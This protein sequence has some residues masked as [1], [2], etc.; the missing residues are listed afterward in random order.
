MWDGLDS[1][2]GVSVKPAARA[3]AP[4]QSNQDTA[5][6]APPRKREPFNLFGGVSFFGG[7]DGALGVSAA[8]PQ[9][10]GAA[11]RPRPTPTPL[12][13]TF[14]PGRVVRDAKDGATRS[15]DANADDDAP[16]LVV[17]V[18][19][20]ESHGGTWDDLVARFVA[21]E[22]SS[23]SFLAVDLRGHGRTPVGNEA[24]FTPAALAADVAACVEAHAGPTRAAGRNV[25][26]VGHSMGA[27]VA[28]RVC[29]DFPGLGARH[30]VAEDM[31][32]RVFEGS[33]HFGEAFGE[34]GF[35]YDRAR[36]FEPNAASVEAMKASLL[37]A[38]GAFTFSK[39]SV[40][41]YVARG[42]LFA[43]SA[44]R[45]VSLVHP[46]GFC[47]AFD[48]ILASG[49]MQSALA[50]IAS[51]PARARPAVHLW[52]APEDC[53]ESC[54]AAAPGVAG[55]VEWIKARFEEG[56]VHDCVFPGAGHS[57]H[58]TRADLFERALRA[59]AFEGTPAAFEDER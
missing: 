6:P 8:K 53:G 12:R 26:L 46:L 39:E 16:P 38:A 52:R 33:A 10:E 19:G 17:F 58:N 24:S 21:S 13:S 54:A 14:T 43:T 20:L 31:D 40:V 44:G 18:H 25:V 22:R 42:R 50:E 29:A 45:A 15:N 59:L 27:R 34:S 41:G 48:R 47:L 49:D 28:A 7:L 4:T 2:L 36:A 37:G 56:A 55:G 5:V 11:G 32:A 1:A 30:L 23:P 9:V 3:P 51:M 35:D 57:V